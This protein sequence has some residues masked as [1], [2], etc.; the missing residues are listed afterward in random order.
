M[1]ENVSPDKQAPILAG[2]AADKDALI[3]NSQVEQDATPPEPSEAPSAPVIELDQPRLAS[4]L[5]TQSLKVLCGAAGWTAFQILPEDARRSTL[6]I[7][8][9]SDTATDRIRIADDPGKLQFES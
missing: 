4:R 1:T 8:V 9:A 3:L 5:L 6:S 7:R 2:D